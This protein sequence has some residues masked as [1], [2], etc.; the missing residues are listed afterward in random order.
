MCYIYSKKIIQNTLFTSTELLDK[1]RNR[2]YDDK[3]RFRTLL[4]GDNSM[5]EN[6]ELSV[7]TVL[8]FIKEDEQIYVDY[9]KQYGLTALALLVL[10]KLYSATGKVS[11]QDICEDFHL[12]K[13]TV[14]SIVKKFIKQEYIKQVP[15]Q[16]CKNKKSILL[17]EK[18][19]NFCKTCIPQ[20]L[21]AEKNAF[22]RLTLEEQKMY[23]SFFRKIIDSKKEE[24]NLVKGKK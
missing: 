19:L 10:E 14:N 17:T 15:M 22:T 23:L 7:K 16:N 6:Y 5:N 13:Q 1:V 11:Q 12:P 9:A 20:L 18:G 8:T 3:V 4:K 2:I 24:L 21:K